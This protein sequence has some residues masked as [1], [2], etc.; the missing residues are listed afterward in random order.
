MLGRLFLDLECKPDGYGNRNA[1][2]QPQ[3]TTGSSQLAKKLAF[4][5][6]KLCHFAGTSD[7]MNIADTG[8]TGSQAAQSVQ[9][10][11]SMYICISFG[12]PCMQSTGQTSTQYN[13]FAPMQGSQITNAKT[14]APYLK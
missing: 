8:Q 12:P 10:T 3:K 9:V 14:D 1:T 2:R 13:S 5:R 7:S 6:M 4:L 11:G